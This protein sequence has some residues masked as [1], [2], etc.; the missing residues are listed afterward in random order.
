MSE[1]SCGRE[2]SIKERGQPISQPRR[3]IQTEAVST[4]LMVL[5]LEP[6]YTKSPLLLQTPSVVSGLEA[7]QFQQLKLNSSFTLLQQLLVSPPGQR[8]TER[9]GKVPEHKER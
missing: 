5:S 7:T 9:S 1:C 6:C 4:E 3:S 2:E 8:Y